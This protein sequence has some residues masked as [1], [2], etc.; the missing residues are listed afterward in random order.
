LKAV[1]F[2]GLRNFRVEDVSKPRPLVGEALVE[3]RAGSICGTDLHFYRGEWTRVKSGQIIGHDACGVRTDS[4][5]RVG[6]I[7]IVHCGSCYFCQRGMPNLCENGK[8][9]GFDEDGFLAEFVAVPNA[10]LLPIPNSVS[11]DEAAVLEP[12][13]LAIHTLNLLQPGLKDWVTIV[14]QGPVGLLMTQMAK[15][16]GCRVIAVDLHDYRLKLSEKYGAD[17]C[18]NAKSENPVKRVRE[19]TQR[20][21]D[22]VI[23]AAGTK[24]MVEQTPYLVRKAGKVALIGE[25]EGYLKVGDASEALFFA[26]SLSSNEYPLAI[27]LISQRAVD[28]KGLITHRFKLADF[29]QAIKVADDFS[30]KPGKV[31]ITA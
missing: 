29:E 10:N 6:M 27:E 19:I 31:V 11:D 22:V 15:L 14:G 9:K 21:S 4:G 24:K 28:V 3:F 18:I 20:G 30:Q 26:G 12:V 5:E 2:R 1:V 16:K 8:T 7:P 13:A 17:A 23:E 25:M